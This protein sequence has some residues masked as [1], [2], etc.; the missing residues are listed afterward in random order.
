MAALEG[1]PEGDPHPPIWTAA[2]VRRRLIAR[3]FLDEVVPFAVTRFIAGSL[4]P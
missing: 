4:T 1:V 3:G 2:V